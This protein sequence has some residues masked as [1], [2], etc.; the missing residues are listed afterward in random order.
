MQFEHES[1]HR[2]GELDVCNTG[3]CSGLPASARRAPV[4]LL[5]GTRNATARAIAMRVL[6]IGGVPAARGG[7][8]LA[9]PVPSEPVERNDWPLQS[10]LIRPQ[11]QDQRP[12]GETW[13]ELVALVGDYAQMLEIVVTSTKI[14]PALQARVAQ[15]QSSAQMSIATQLGLLSALVGFRAEVRIQAE[16][17]VGVERVASNSQGRCVG[18]VVRDHLAARD[19]HNR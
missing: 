14:S 18:R 2:D 13:F 10:T 3:T 1:G 9:H 5:Y 12:R 15:A 11:S 8:C 17:A 4:K 7:L 6:V 19:I 16:R